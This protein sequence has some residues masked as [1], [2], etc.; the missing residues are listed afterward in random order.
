MG[1]DY[2]KILG[3]DK[4][5]SES[6]LKKAYRKM[7]LKY[8]PDK[9]KSPGAEEKF[10]EVAE[11]YEVL[12]DKDK[13]AVYD[14]YG[15]EGLR[16]GGGSSSSG[17]TG[18]PRMY[19]FTSSGGNG[20]NVDPFETF[21]QFFGNEDPFASFFGGS[22]GQGP[23]M[24]SNSNPGGRRMYTNFS[25]FNNGHQHMDIDDDMGYSMNM[26]MGMPQS[27]LS[28]SRK[29]QD[30]PITR[31]LPLG[32]DEVYSGVTKR[33]KMK[34][35]V[36]K[37]NQ[38]SSE[39][40]VLSIDVKPGWKSG[41]KITFPKEGDQ[42]PNVIPADIVF[43]VKDKPHP[44]FKRDGSDI[45]CKRPISLRQALCGGE[46]RVPLVEGGSM[47]YN[48]TDIVKPGN[49]KR[50]VGRGL[51]LPKEPGARG[52]LIL[53]FDIQFPNT[54]PESTKRQLREVLPAP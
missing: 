34:K 13:K 36:L 28:G 30:P 2:Y 45:R 3:V 14:R 12:S 42:K 47:T 44:V 15:E 26:N 40:K 18:G 23:T 35:Q 6:D 25:N 53:E 51:P 43:V 21:R 38:I 8:H 16:A 11:A 7:A 32:L 10:K 19:T 27:G 46:V 9:N 4:N 1:K 17:G 52:D 39:E 54:L 48:I 37:N 31:D 22:G 20:P 50:I 41:T 49:S 33:M 24:G 29:R 5:V